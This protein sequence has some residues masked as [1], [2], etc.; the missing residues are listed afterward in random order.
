MTAALEG[1]EWSAARPGRTLPPRKTQYPFYRRLGGP[2]GWSGWAENLVPTGIWSRTIQPIVSC[3]TNWATRPTLF[4]YIVEKKEEQPKEE[5]AVGITVSLQSCLLYCQNIDEQNMFFSSF[6]NRI[7]ADPCTL[8][9]LLHLL[10]FRQ[11]LLLIMKTSVGH[12]HLIW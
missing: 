7:A 3:Y 11:L 10:N 12:I 9:E 2:Q 8:L 4:I 5:N 1:G 6:W